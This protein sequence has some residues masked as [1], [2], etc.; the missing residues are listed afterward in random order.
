MHSFRSFMCLI[1]TI[2]V[3][4][5]VNNDDPIV[6]CA[7][8]DYAVPGLLIEIVDANGNNLVK[9]GTYD[10]DEIAVIIDDTNISRILVNEEFDHIISILLSDA[11]DGTEAQ[12]ILSSSET[13]VLKVE[14]TRTTTG[15]PCFFSI[16]NVDEVLY[17]GE[18]TPVEDLPFNQKI[19]V[20]K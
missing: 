5:C 12:V 15:E 20:T 4:S 6:Q 10:K 1:L 16:F 3:F 13:D 7:A 19:T 9:N 17:N 18:I 14:L 2:T 11:L 8:I